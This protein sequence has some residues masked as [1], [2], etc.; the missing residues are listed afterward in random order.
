MDPNFVDH[1]LGALVAR[2]LEYLVFV[3]FY[4]TAIY[5]GVQG[6]F[7][8]CGLKLEKTSLDEWVIAMLGMAFALMLDLNMWFYV[9]G[10]TN[11]QWAYSV[12][13]RAEQGSPSAWFPVW[14]IILFC[15]LTTG[16]MV[17]GGKRVILGVTKE[18]GDGVEALKTA[19]RQN[20]Q[21]QQQ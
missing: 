6:L 9:N 15:N 19:L 20:G 13:L 5:G 7:R 12:A 1:P 21:N 16:A 18:F 11:A 10:Q 17:V 8:F 3:L 2:V 14:L 4:S